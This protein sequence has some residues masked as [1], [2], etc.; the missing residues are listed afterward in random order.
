[1]IAAEPEPFIPSSP[2]CYLP[3]LSDPASLLSA[4]LEAA[5][6][7]IFEYDAFPAIKDEIY[8]EDGESDDQN[9]GR[10]CN[11]Q[12]IFPELESLPSDELFPNPERMKKEDLKVEAGLTPPLPTPTYPKTV[13]F[14][15]VVEEMLLDHEYSDSA[16][17]RADSRN[18][19]AFFLH[20]GLYEVLEQASETVNRKVEQ[21]QL[22]EAATT[23]KVHVPNMD[24][25]LPEPP[26]KEL[27]KLRFSS[28]LSQA[29]N[30]LIST[31]KAEHGITNSIPGIRKLEECL[32]WTPFPV[33]LA[34]IALEEELGS[35]NDFL[36]FITSL[37]GLNVVTSADVTYKKPGLRIV[38][39]A[40]DDGN[41][42]LEP[43]TFL[44]EQSEDLASLLR[45]RKLQ[46]GID[47]VLSNNQLSD[48]STTPT[49]GKRPSR[50]A[51]EFVAAG[52]LIAG[53]NEEIPDNLIGGQFSA[54][55]SLDNF[56]EMRGKKK[57][58]LTDSNYF[59]S[60]QVAPIP[61]P[62]Y[63]PVAQN[64]PIPHV[65][66]TDL[67]LP[68]LQP[69]STSTPFIISTSLLNLRPLVKTVQALFPTAQFIER[70]FT[71]H[72]TTS[73]LKPGTIVRSPIISSL[74]SEADLIISPSTG[75]VLTSLTRIKQKPL[76][77]QKAK[78]EIRE[79]IEAVSMRYERL[80]VFISEGSLDES[81]RGLNG[82]DCMA[83]TEFLAF[84]ASLPT[85]A[86][87]IFVPG[88]HQTLAKWLVSAMI[89][90]GMHDPVK[91]G[92]LEEETIWELFL[93]RCGMNSYAA[94]SVS[95]ELK[96]PE[97][98]NLK[99]PSKHGIYGIC[100]F[101]EMDHEERIRRFGALLGGERVLG[102]VSRVIDIPWRDRTP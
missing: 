64:I 101:V 71:R 30:T 95:A 90:H 61:P 81:S 96:A 63:L 19:N 86:N 56:M 94:Q 50:I 76:P 36:P 43:G 23:K 26:W 12:D 45:K 18:E 20:D 39:E 97:G 62:Q 35:D 77:G 55:L 98:V 68:L 57:Q 59:A 25:A 1:L 79:K 4:D 70:D 82:Q 3:L 24:F 93:R 41:E 33:N 5:E 60:S 44:A 8:Q 84:C 80:L 100:A 87:V 46:V 102:M 49:R 27:E 73:W 11:P 51:N 83:F 78:T 10:F 58:K 7:V 40:E 28:N 34:R 17:S 29:Q 54:A 88:G 67:A 66:K 14:S 72:N 74:A 52:Q 15:D 89:E 92:L 47:E 16:S 38:E 32:R 21:E 48:S 2:D 75:A 99:S 65:M 42:D 91:A 22:Q 53:Q 69:P 6:K 31:M 9:R 37:N 85:S 13:T